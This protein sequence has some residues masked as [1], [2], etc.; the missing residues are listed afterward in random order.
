MKKPLRLMLK[1]MLTAI[2]ILS[3]DGYFFTRLP[4]FPKAVKN[5]QKSPME[6]RW[7]SV[8]IVY[9]FSIASLFYFVILPNKSVAEGAFLGMITYGIFDFSNHAIFKN[10]GLTLAVIDVLWGTVLFAITTFIVKALL[11]N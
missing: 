2:I 3:I 9:I 8:I 4:L 6:L 7:Y 10:Y 5:I 11:P 1:L